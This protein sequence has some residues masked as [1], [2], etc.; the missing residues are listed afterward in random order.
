MQN[1]TVHVLVQNKSSCIVCMKLVILHNVWNMLFLIGDS[2]SYLSGL[3]RLRI[4][5][6]AYFGG[7]FWH[8]L[9]EAEKVGKT[10]QTLNQRKIQISGICAE[11][12]LNV[13]EME[14]RMGDGENQ[15]TEN[16]INGNLWF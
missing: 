6:W 8:F 16:W 15:W 13:E 5:V 14:P 4:N 7:F 2:K 9:L 12:S 11:S 10:E 3:P 1:M